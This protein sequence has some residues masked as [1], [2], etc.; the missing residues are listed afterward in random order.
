MYKIKFT[1][2]ALT[3]LDKVYRSDRKL[4][5]R[6]IAAI[7]PLKNNPY[8]GK[9]LMGKLTG[10]YSLRAGNYRVIYTV[11]HSALVIYIIDLGHRREIYR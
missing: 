2:S 4:Y 11:R 3:E 10:D 8:L 9:K 6:L 1:E 5:S 7:E